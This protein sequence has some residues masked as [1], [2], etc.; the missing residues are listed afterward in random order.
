MSVS[1][2]I[3]ETGEYAYSFQVNGS[4]VMSSPLNLGYSQNSSINIPFGINIY[5]AAHTH[6]LN[7]FYMFSFSDVIILLNLYSQANSTIKND[8]VFMLINPDGS[9]YAIK[10]DDIDI[11]MA[12]IQQKFN[13]T[14]IYGGNIQAK[15]NAADR[16]LNQIYQNT[17][18]PSDSD[19]LARVFLEHFNGS[20]M[21]LYKSTG[22]FDGWK[23]LSLPTN[24]SSST[25]TESLCD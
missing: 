6:P 3:E 25:L 2:G 5:G 12:N 16:K 19:K 17:S 1:A 9:A 14:G 10:I 23:K 8:D 7:A 21:S 24:S 11:F 15:V 4:N 22:N 13:A 18:M 20:G